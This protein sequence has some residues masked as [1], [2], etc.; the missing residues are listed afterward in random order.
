MTR[1]TLRVAASFALP[2]LLTGLTAV[3]ATPGSQ[4]TAASIVQIGAREDAAIRVHTIKE[5]KLVRA[6]KR[7]L[8]QQYDF[9]CGSA[10][11]ATLLTFQ[12]GRPTDE[13]TVFTA[14]FAAGDQ[15]QIRSKGFSLLDMKHFLEANGY[16]ADG[17]R[18]SLDTLAQVGVPGIAL[19]SDHGYRHFIV[20]KGLDERRVLIGDPALGARMLT[21][22]EFERARVGD[23]FFVIRSH[24]DIAHFNSRADW[25]ATLSAPL[26]TA[27]DRNLLGLEL[28]TIPDSSRF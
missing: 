4:V 16:Q 28:L 5:I 27:V 12:Y 15:A 19:I 7:T 14:M 13:T 6:F 9:S 24:R 25:D 1:L 18:T 8:H 2:I 20:V 11:V 22:R 26:S 17:V 23:L 10:A 3:G 21:R